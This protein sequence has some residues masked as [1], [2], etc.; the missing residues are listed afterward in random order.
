MNCRQL[1]QTDYLRL[2]AATRALNKMA[3][4]HVA[5]AAVTRVEQ[6]AFSRYGAPQHE[7]CFMPIDVVA[8]LE[9]EVGGAPVTRALAALS[10]LLVIPVPPAGRPGMVGGLGEIA[11]EAGEAIARIG[12]ALADDG[13]VT[14]EEIRRL[15]LR[16]EVREAME[17]LAGMDTLLAAIEGGGS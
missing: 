9:A 1:P 13:R 14:A 4:G 2:K 5:A 6:Q 7:G 16:E 8:D 3:G 17:A 10:G 11:K 15:A 12:E